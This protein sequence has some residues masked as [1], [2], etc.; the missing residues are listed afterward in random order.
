MKKGDSI[1]IFD[2][3]DLEEGT[4]QGKHHELESVWWIAIGNKLPNLC[5][6]PYIYKKPKDKIKLLHNIDLC[7]KDLQDMARKISHDY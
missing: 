1:W 6:E 5:I 4:V 3:R 7:I 2:R